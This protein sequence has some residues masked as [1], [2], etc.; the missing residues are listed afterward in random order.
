MFKNWLINT[1]SRS[2]TDVGQE[3]L[4]CRNLETKSIPQTGYFASKSI[5]ELFLLC[6]IPLTDRP[7]YWSVATQQ[8]VML[9]IDSVGTS[10]KF[11]NNFSFKGLFVGSDHL[12]STCTT[13]SAFAPF[14]DFIWAVAQVVIRRGASNTFSTLKTYSTC[15]I[16]FNIYMFGPWGADVPCLVLRIGEYFTC[17]IRCNLTVWRPTEGRGLFRSFIHVRS[18]IVHS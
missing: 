5:A 9:C 17:F 18:S 2:D 3:G 14:L 16:L 6:G 7:P 11:F 8:A 4:T 1:F 15:S 10:I 13:D 12:H